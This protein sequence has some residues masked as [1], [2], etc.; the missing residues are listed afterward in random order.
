[1]IGELGC[2]MKRL[3]SNTSRDDSEVPMAKYIR[4]RKRTALS[5]T[6]GSIIRD[7][8]T[9]DDNSRL[10]AGEKETVTRNKIAS[11]KRIMLDST[12]NLH[13][14]CL[15]EN[16]NIKV[17]YATFARLRPYYVVQ[18]SSDKRDTCPVPYYP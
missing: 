4:K 10:T 17:S 13:A 5:W 12:K 1:M 2:S 8:Y 11:R 7:F 6:A 3:R 9:M 14:K 15:A 16:S 18:Q